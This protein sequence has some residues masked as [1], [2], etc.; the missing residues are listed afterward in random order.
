MGALGQV[1]QT[2]AVLV[3][4]PLLSNVFNISDVNLALVGYVA[5]LFLN[6]IKGSWL[7]PI[8]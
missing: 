5:L 1:L 8:G 6:L 2:V 7:S 4:V 3:I